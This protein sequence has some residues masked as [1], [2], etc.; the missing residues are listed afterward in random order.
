M[1]S[2]DCDTGGF[3]WVSWQP[4]LLVALYGLW[5]IDYRLLCP[6]SWAI[7]LPPLAREQC[8]FRVRQA[9]SSA[10]G[11][12]QELRAAVHSFSRTAFAAIG[13]T[14]LA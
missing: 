1:R 5:A 8:D 14:W 2:Q 10:D 6:A 9:H 4:P 11:W 3:S 13:G 7:R 12:L